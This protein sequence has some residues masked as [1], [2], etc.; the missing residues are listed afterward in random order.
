MTTLK[1]DASPG[2]KQKGIPTDK[3]ARKA[4]YEKIMEIYAAQ[5][6]VKF[7]AKKKELEKKRDGFEY[8]AG[9]WVNIF[10]P[11]TVKEEIKLTAPHPYED[12]DFAKS[13]IKQLRN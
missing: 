8:I 11:N 10:D 6:P 1:I 5:N 4:Y 13:A 9:R 12:E 3:E 7:A 2:K